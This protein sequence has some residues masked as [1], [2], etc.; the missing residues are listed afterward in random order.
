MQIKLRPRGVGIGFSDGEEE[1]EPEDREEVSRRDD[2]KLREEFGYKKAKTSTYQQPTRPGIVVDEEFFKPANEPVQII[3]MT[4]TSDSPL[5]SLKRS[6]LRSQQQLETKIALNERLAEEARR[7]LA[8]TAQ[9]ISQL[10]IKAAATRQSIETRRALIAALNEF[11][12][13]NENNL[14]AWQEL[15]KETNSVIFNCLIV[16]NYKKHLL[17]DSNQ[18]LLPVSALCQASLTPQQSLQLFYHC[19]WPAHRSLFSGFSV[20]DLTG[21]RTCLDMLNEWKPVLPRE[22]FQLPYLAAQILIPRLHSMLTVSEG[23]VDVAAAFE[24]VS[25]LQTYFI[26]FLGMP[27]EVYTQLIGG[28]VDRFMARTIKSLSLERC[29]ALDL[30]HALLLQRISHALAREF[31]VDPSDQDVSVLDEVFS[32][33]L[34]PSELGPLLATHVTPKLLA[35]LRKWLRSPQAE[36]E[37]IAEWYEAWKGIFEDILAENEQFDAEFSKLLIEIDAFLNK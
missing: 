2:A 22:S 21:W 25:D 31:I 28:D 17:P 23:I 8:R 27:T 6:L 11:K 36:L 15:L 5:V 10:E 4:S 3:D 32:F 18:L 9:E 30:P 20:T 33:N 34:S 24:I 35:T 29:K 14:E 37:E 16:P 13:F 7:S 26:N 19:W 1:E 12:T